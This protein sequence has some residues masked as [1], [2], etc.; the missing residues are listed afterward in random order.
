MHI[1]VNR[2][3]I[4]PEDLSI[5]EI[6][7][8]QITITDMDHSGWPTASPDTRLEFGLANPGK[9]NMIKLVRLLTQWDLMQ[10]KRFVDNNWWTDPSNEQNH[11]S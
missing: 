10:S 8:I 1:V 4:M 5:S 3:S 2:N 6:P 9:I 11:G 7:N